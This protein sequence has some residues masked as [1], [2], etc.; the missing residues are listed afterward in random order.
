M[1]STTLRFYGHAGDSRGVKTE[2]KVSID[3]LD[4][5]IL[6]MFDTWDCAVLKCPPEALRKLCSDLLLALDGKYQ[7]PEKPLIRAL[8]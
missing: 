7:E 3:P 5:C 2:L 4:G 6:T 1:K 8:K